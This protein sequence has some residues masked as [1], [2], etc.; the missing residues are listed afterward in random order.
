MASRERHLV[1]L[2]PGSDPQRG[3]PSALLN[4]LVG[5]FRMLVAVL[6]LVP[7]GFL[8]RFEIVHPPH[9]VGSA[10]G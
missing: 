1:T 8:T 3:R 5:P 6:L 7:G 2:P 10:S 9:A 4:R